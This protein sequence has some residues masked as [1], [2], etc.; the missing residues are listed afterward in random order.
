MLGRAPFAPWRGAVRVGGLVAALA[1]LSGCA[2]DEPAAECVRDENCRNDGLFCNGVPR[3][4][5]VDGRGICV[6][7]DVPCAAPG[8][9]C[10]EDGDRCVPCVVDPSHP[11]CPQ[12]VP[13]GGFTCDDQN[14]GTACVEPVEC[15]ASV[16]QQEAPGPGFPVRTEDGASGRRLTATAFPDGYCGVPC[17]PQARNDECGD[18]ATC[19]A[20]ALAGNV[21]YPVRFVNPDLSGVCRQDCTPTN[22]GTGCAR[23]GYTCDPE[24]RTCLEA[25]VDDAQCQIVLRD[26]DGDGR[27]EYLDRGADFPAYCDPVTGR[28]RTR[29]TPGVRVGDTCTDDDQCMDDGRCVF[30]EPGG[31]GICALPGCRDGARDCPAGSICDVR[32]VDGGELSACLPRC[33]VGL[34]EGTDAA[35]GVGAGHPDCGPGFACVWSGGI[36]GPEA[37]SCV[38]G[39]YNAVTVPNVGTP[40]LVDEECWSP[41]GY[42]DCRFGGGG[43]SPVPGLC[44]VRHCSTFLDGGGEE[45]DGLLSRAVLDDPVCDREDGDECVVFGS[46]STDTFCLRRCVDTGDCAPGQACAELFSGRRHCWPLCFFDEDCPGGERCVAPGGDACEGRGGCRCGS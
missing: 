8:L 2:C 25:C 33:T 18:C 32:N 21:R 20:D 9:W 3:C 43:P 23:A 17:R 29:G 35:L 7:A 10:D 22:D 4:A 42:G 31:T 37:G 44:T 46:G 39:H 12:E 14:P 1:G 26:I 36:E 19:G 11:S 40:C 16:C 13:D 38:R 45:I 15:G 41:F 28:C 27:E 5:T 34:E 24:T 6:Q 30:L